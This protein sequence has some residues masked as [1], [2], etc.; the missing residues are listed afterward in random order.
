[1][2]GGGDIQVLTGQNS[3]IPS[4]A[5]RSA[6]YLVD[7]LLRHVEQYAGQGLRVWCSGGEGRGAPLG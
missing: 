7:E 4:L 3:G 6:V 5:T 2:S 1:M